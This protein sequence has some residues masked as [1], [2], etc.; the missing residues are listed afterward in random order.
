MLQKP[1]I[2][3]E[4]IIACVHE[5]Y[6]LTIQEVEFLP[7]GADPYAAVYHVR[8][9]EKSY[10]LKLRQGRIDEISLLIPHFL[11]EQGIHEIIAPLTTKVGKLWTELENFSLILYPFVDGHNAWDSHLSEQN[12]TVFG[13]AL[14]AV[15]SAKLSP[16]LSNHLPKEAFSNQWREAMKDFMQKIETDIFDEPIAIKLAAFLQSKRA[17]ILDLVECSEHYASKLMCKELEF[18]LC[19]ADIHG[20][21]V[22]LD[23]KDSFYIVDWDTPMLSPKERDLMFVT[24]DITG[25]WF[26][27]HNEQAFL[28]GYDEIELDADALAYYR[29]ERIIEDIA[30]TCQQIFLSDEGGDDRAM[31]LKIVMDC[32]SADGIIDRVKL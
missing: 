14:K 19:H 13:Q 15:H 12:W 25:V 6:D 27:T 5:N 11:V 2:E 32:F 8:D 16:D 4:K 22:L 30:V 10:F 9:T 26:P 1:D 3:D 20:W 31:G 18:V 24:G 17:V 23:N 7:L 28:Q 21:N 29:Y